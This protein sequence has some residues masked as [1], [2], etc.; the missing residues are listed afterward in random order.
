MCIMKKTNIRIN[1]LF[2]I[3]DKNNNYY[4]S[5]ID[6]IEEWKEKKNLE[7]KEYKN[8]D[9]TNIINNLMEENNIISNTNF[10]GFINTKELLS[11]NKIKIKKLN[12][13]GG[14]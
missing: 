13:E 1:N 11:K 6:D 12:H 5:D 8:N 3:I 2:L 9:V 14:G 7:L 10:C 4:L